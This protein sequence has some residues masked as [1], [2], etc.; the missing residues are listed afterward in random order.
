MIICVYTL[1]L[2]VY[3]Q[4]QDNTEERSSTAGAETH[5]V[6]DVSEKESEVEEEGDKEEPE[7]AGQV[8]ERQEP[9]LSTVTDRP[10]ASVSR[11]PP[12]I[13]PFPHLHTL[14][15]ANNMVSS[16]NTACTLTM[17]MYIHAR[18]IYT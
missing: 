13:A 14:S 2:H 12:S 3:T 7:V 4:G 8:R 15:L 6:Q 11:L 17:Y 18:F 16:M 5:E 10:P 1:Y 9:Q